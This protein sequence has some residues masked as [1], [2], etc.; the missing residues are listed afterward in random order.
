[1]SELRWNTPILRKRMRQLWADPNFFVRT[2]LPLDPHDGQATWLSEATQPINILV[3]GNRFGKSTVIAMRHIWHCFG[4]VG[5]KP[6]PKETWMTMPYETI[7]VAHSADQAEIVFNMAKRMLKHPA[8]KPFVKRIYSTPFPRIVFYNGAVMH[9]RSA[10]D[11]GKYIDGHAYR[12]ISID[13]AGYIDNLKEL[14]TSV[15]IMRLAG[16]GLIDLIGTPKGYGDLY[17]YANRGMQKVKGYYTQRG[18]IYDNPHLSPEDIKMRD[19]LLKHADPRLREQVIYGEFVSMAGM[20]FTKDQLENAFVE[21]M[22]AHQDWIPGH[23]YVQAW[24]LGRRTDFTVGITLDV[25]RT[26]W[27]LVDFVRLNKVPWETIYEI[28]GRKSLEYHVSMPIIDATG[29]QGDVIEEELRKRGIWI[30]GV[31]TSTQALKTELINTLQA[32]LDHDRIQIGERDWIDEAMVLHKVPDLEPPRTEPWSFQPC[33]HS[34]ATVPLD[35]HGFA[36]EPG[37]TEYQAW[38]RRQEQVSCFPVEH[39]QPHSWGWLRMPVI[40]QLVDEMGV[41]QFDD[42]DLVQDCVFALALAVQ[43]RYQ[44]LY[45]PLPGLKKVVGG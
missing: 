22:P 30:M 9:C 3:P 31:K 28:I 1:M 11:G 45:D 23:R 37:S 10:H 5:A 8:I 16:G 24:D 14:M 20:A 29:P 12:F 27:Q 42:K 34:M 43:A 13:E 21:G 17:W 4:K 7:S 25:T 36:L 38:L 6:G 26:P 18:S 41:Y 15:I 35:G 19:D 40:T 39:R 44:L 2:L 32:C 33:Q